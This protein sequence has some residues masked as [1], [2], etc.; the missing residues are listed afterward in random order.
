[1]STVMKSSDQDQCSKQP[2]AI[3]V[4]IVVMLC[5]I[6]GTS[7]LLATTLQLEFLLLSQDSDWTDS[8]PGIL[9][10]P[11]IAGAA[12]VMGIILGTFTGRA[13][14]LCLYGQ[15]EKARSVCLFGGRLAIGVVL[16]FCIEDLFT[17]Q[18]KINRGEMYHFVLPSLSILWGTGLLLYGRSGKKYKS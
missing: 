18:A 9:H 17:I 8:A 13:I 5:V 11:M 14:I 6:A 2:S 7:V 4:C 1:M 10:G 15:V 12:S 3:S 16:F